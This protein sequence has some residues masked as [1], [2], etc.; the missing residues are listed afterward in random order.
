MINFGIVGFG[1]AAQV[2]HMPLLQLVGTANTKAAITAVYSAKP[3]TAVHRYLPQATVFNDLAEFFASADVDVVIVTTPNQYHGS[4]ARQAL[5]ADKH[6]IIDKPFVPTVTEG[7]DLIE[8]AEQRQKVLTV[9]HNRR[10]DGDFLTIQRLQTEAALGEIRYFE[11]RFDKYRPQIR[12]HWKDRD[13]PGT[14]LL[15][16]IGS[17][18]IDQALTLFG[19]PETVTATLLNSRPGAVSNDYFDVQLGFAQQR[20]IA[21]L[22]GS[23]CVSRS[24][25][26][27]YLEGTGGTYQK[28]HLDGQEAQLRAVIAA[29]QASTATELPRLQLHKLERTLGDAPK[30]HWGVLTTPDASATGGTKEQ[31]IATER[32]SYRT[33]YE[34]L[35]A[36]LTA[37]PSGNT[38]RR[39]VGL[40]NSAAQLPVTAAQALQV[41]QVIELAQTSA[42]QGKTLAF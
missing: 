8:L 5:L 28:S 24:P 4:I 25:F 7:A 30:A 29:Q 13:K 39:S 18:L 26:R 42:R 37:F 31:L 22:R 19:T 14:G 3:A 15:F 33:F 34:R 11:S 40:D 17:H 20:C 16:D 2:F 21:R 12:D 38:E 41:I 6:V 27:F 35:L 9:Y 1:L 10:W 32:G 36:V 23:C